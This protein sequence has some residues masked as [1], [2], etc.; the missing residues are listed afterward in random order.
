MRRIQREARP[1]QPH[2]T[3][4]GLKLGWDEVHRQRTDELR[5]GP[6]RGQVIEPFRPANLLQASFMED[7]NTVG[8]AQCLDLIM[9]DVDQGPTERFV[10]APDSNPLLFGPPGLHWLDRSDGL[11]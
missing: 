10:Q 1:G 8:E 11:G 9:S 3:V 5:N 4:F 7:R 6:I 2:Q